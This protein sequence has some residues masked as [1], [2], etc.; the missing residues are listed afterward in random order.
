MPFLW[1]PATRVDKIISSIQ[2]AKDRTGSDGTIWSVVERK[3]NQALRLDHC[4]YGHGRH[5][6]VPRSRP[7]FIGDAAALHG[8]IP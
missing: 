3:Q 4:T 6:L 7:V 1:S 5:F 2:C 8:A